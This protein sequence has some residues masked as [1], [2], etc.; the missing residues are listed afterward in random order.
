MADMTCLIT[1]AASGIGRAVAL[2]LAAPATRLVLHTR[3]NREGLEAV[4]AEAEAKGAETVLAL[5]DLSGPEACAAAVEA[6]GGRLD[7]L[8]S[9]AGYSDKRRIAD[10]PEDAIR[11][12]HAGITD[13]FFHLIRAAQPLLAASGQGR[14]VAVSSFVAHRFPPGG[15][16]FPA[17]AQAKAGLEALACAFAAEMAP[18]KVTVNVVSPG[19]IQKDA[20]AH[21]AL[22]AV[23]FREMA[24]RIPFARLGAPDEVA[25]AIAFLLQPE[26]GYITGQIIHVDGGIGLA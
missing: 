8:V 10:L 15:T 3:K 19:Y 14:V 6:A 25:A 20:G 1:G 23:Q 9:N 5:G 4:A 22:T 11:Y 7:W 17:S 24:A 13:A 18:H 2:R 26:A 21:S 16:L 12:A